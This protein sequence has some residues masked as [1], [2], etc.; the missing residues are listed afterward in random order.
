[1][2]DEDN[3]KDAKNPSAAPKASAAS[4]GAEKAKRAPRAAKGTGTK[5]AGTKRTADKKTKPSSRSVAASVK[6][7]ASVKDTDVNT[8]E[9][10]PSQGGT[11]KAEAPKAETPKAEA[12]KAE[13]PKAETPKAETPKAETLK[14]ET[15]KAETKVGAATMAPPVSPTSSPKPSLAQA[16]MSPPP[17]SWFGKSGIALFVSVIAVV[18]AL[19][20]PQWGPIV[21]DLEESEEADTLAL[22]QAALAQTVEALQARIEELS[23]TQ[24][25]FARSIDAVKLPGMLIVAKSLRDDLGTSKPFAENL[26][27][28]RAIVGD[29]EEGLATVFSL[30]DRAEIGVPTEAELRARFDDVAYA[31]VAA[32]QTV[33]SDG[34]LARKLSET[35]ASLSAVTTRLRW[36]LDGAPTGEGSTAAVARAE[37]LVDTLAFDEA[38]EQ[39]QTLPD[40]LK[41]LTV[42]WVASVKARAALEIAREELDIYMIEAVARTR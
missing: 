7:T 11:T 36:K 16:P 19:T 42:D 30:D 33:Q 10:K 32:E 38:I 34:D 3:G 2:T 26:N 40:D 39:L 4:S 5:R 14:A 12:P 13:A 1:M 18:L 28:L 31:I 21:W 37:A 27:L 35:M 23:T 41:A 29:D 25:G 6:E 9:T 17:E 24:V 22:E 20:A 8:P 15:P